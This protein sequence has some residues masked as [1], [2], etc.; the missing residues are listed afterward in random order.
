MTATRQ[1]SLNALD[2]TA[3]AFGSDT[4]LVIWR[5]D[6][7]CD[8]LDSR[9]DVRDSQALWNLED[10][11]LRFH[12]KEQG[13]RLDMALQSAGDALD[14]ATGPTTLIFIGDGENTGGPLAPWIQL[15]AASP[16][17]GSVV[18]IGLSPDFRKPRIKDFAPL[19]SRF[20]PASF[21][22][23]SAALGLAHDELLAAPTP[24]P[25]TNTATSA[26]P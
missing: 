17:L 10:K 21:E 13:S 15:L 19:G 12:K 8:Q 5:Y 14:R 23:S 3:D 26:A 11:E 24:L 2:Q 7:R 6:T 4:T 18:F 22:G 1:S 20:H 9:D 25:T 16:H